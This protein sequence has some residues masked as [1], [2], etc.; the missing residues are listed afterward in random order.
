MALSA[1]IQK[2]SVKHD[3]IMN[4]ILVNPTV[5]LGVVAR[6]FGVTA[7]WLSTIIHSDA[8]Q[9]QLRRKKD[10]MFNTHV[11]PL[12][13]KLLG[14]AHVAVERLGEQL[15]KTDNPDYIADT[16]VMLLD[17]VGFSPKSPAPAATTMNVQ[18]N[19]YQVDRATLEEARAAIGRRLGATQ[20]VVSEVDATG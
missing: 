1:S 11:L 6:H 14:L 8:F 20:Q 16:A 10:A 7:P 19:I 4:Y 17:R 3:T 13:E 18:N 2:V 15:D 5:P 9:A 12:G